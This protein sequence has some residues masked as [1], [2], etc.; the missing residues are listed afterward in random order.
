MVLVLLGTQNNSFHRLL[1]EIQRLMDKKVIQEK[2]VV[3]AGKTHFISKNMEIFDLVDQD[4]LNELIEQASYIITHGGVGSILTCVKAGKKVIAVARKQEYGEHV[5]NHQI[6]IV[7][8]FDKAGYLKGIIEVKD[9][10]EAIQEL[11]NFKPEEFVSN[12][13]N[14][15]NIIEKFIER[16][17]KQKEVKRKKK[18]GKC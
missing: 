14:M 4:K 8:S 10:E 16:D 12:T 17:S 15:I 9:L 3:Q 11:K 2:V 6:Q 5:N 13:D 7:E 18:K 1:E